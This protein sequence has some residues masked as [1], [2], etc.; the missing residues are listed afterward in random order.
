M[1]YGDGH[2]LGWMWLWGLLWFA[3]VAG[4]I[5]LVIWALSRGLS[6]GRCASGPAPD[7]ALE[8]LRERFAR[9]EID[10]ADYLARRRVLL[11]EGSERSAP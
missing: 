11:S 7:R 5:A 1:M 2:M 4:G 10:E 3:V 8:A 6:G 9:G